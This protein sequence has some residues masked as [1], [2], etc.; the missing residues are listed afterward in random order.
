M[1]WWLLVGHDNSSFWQEQTEL[2]SLRIWA[3][4][5]VGVRLTPLLILVS[6]IPSDTLPAWI[7]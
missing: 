1:D 2:A 6:Q 5:T 3:N 7:L 4:S